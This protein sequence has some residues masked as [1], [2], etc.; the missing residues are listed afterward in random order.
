MLYVLAAYSGDESGGG[1]DMRI[2]IAE[3]EQRAREGLSKLL[4]TIPGDYELVGQAANGQAAL[5]MILRL[6]PDVV[7]TDIKMPFLDGLTLIH[8]VREQQLSTEF[9]VISAYADFELARRSISLGVAEYVLKPVTREDI[10]RTLYRLRQRI[11]SGRRYSVQETQSLREKY[12]EA[13]PLILRALDMVQS[14]YAGKINQRELA[15]GLGISAEYF[16]YLFSKN[17]GETFSSFLRTYRIQQ[18]KELYRNGNCERKDVPYAVGFSDAKYFNQVFRKVT[19]KS[20]TEYLY[21]CG[22][23]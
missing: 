21:E 23:D 20:P 3:D 19:G 18:A 13:H 7:F 10:E 8:A 6:R 2:V 11:D 1:Y 4:H 17:I 5:E 22:E 16:S 14:C 9:V 15:E 12:P